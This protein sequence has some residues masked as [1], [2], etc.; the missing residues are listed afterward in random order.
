[1]AVCS[2]VVIPR[3]VCLFSCVYDVAGK[4]G[5]RASRRYRTLLVTTEIEG[6]KPHVA[7]RQLLGC[8]DSCQLRTSACLVSRRPIRLVRSAAGYSLGWRVGWRIA[9]RSFCMI[10][11][12]S[13]CSSVSSLPAGVPTSGRRDGS[14][15]VGGCEA[16]DHAPSTYAGASSCRRCQGRG[17]AA[18]RAC[19]TARGRRGHRRLDGDSRITLASSFA[20]CFFL[21]L[22]CLRSP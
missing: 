6:R 7:N 21:P 11:K 4:D 15:S 1:M 12:V 17:T 14:C 10:A 22:T 3:L 8:Y 16:G 5:G 18:W 19:S 13:H 9:T 2:Q 20:M